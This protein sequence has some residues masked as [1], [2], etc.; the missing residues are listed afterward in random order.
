MISLEDKMKTENIVEV[1]ESQINI[2]SIREVVVGMVTPSPFPRLE[3]REAMA[4]SHFP[5]R[6]G[7]SSAWPW[8]S[9]SLS[10]SLS[11]SSDDDR[12]LSLHAN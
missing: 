7:S 11:L 6:E 8:P 4:T 5:H 1:G 10:L 9:L 2:E 12:N 3:K